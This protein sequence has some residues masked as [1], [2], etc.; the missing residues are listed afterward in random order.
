MLVAA[1]QEGI[2]RG[3]AEHGFESGWLE[4]NEAL[5]HALDCPTALISWLSKEPTFPQL[6]Q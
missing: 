5:L 4:L 3:L 2:E 1:M 6:S